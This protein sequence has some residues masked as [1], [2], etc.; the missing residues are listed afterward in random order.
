MNMSLVESL[1][2][3][4]VPVGLAA[5]VQGAEFLS[6]IDGKVADADELD[7][8]AIDP[9]SKGREMMESIKQ[10]DFVQKAVDKLSSDETKENKAKAK[11]TAIE[12]FPALKDLPGQF[13][14]AEFNDE[15]KTKITVSILVTKVNADSQMS[16]FYRKIS[17]VID[18][19]IDAQYTMKWSQGSIEIWIDRSKASGSDSEKQQQDP[20]P[21]QYRH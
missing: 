4:M 18:A 5:V 11:Q 10:S 17:Y 7:G 1:L 14:E 13:F 19:A 12:A 6:K 3:V 20:F 16:D 15:T 2:D 9:F 8:G 21:N